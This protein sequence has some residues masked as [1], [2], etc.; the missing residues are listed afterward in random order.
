M[1]TIIM[2]LKNIAYLP[3]QKKTRIYFAIELNLWKGAK[4]L[5]KTMERKISFVAACFRKVQDFAY[6]AIKR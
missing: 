4:F 2:H 5:K 3:V 6:F 1:F